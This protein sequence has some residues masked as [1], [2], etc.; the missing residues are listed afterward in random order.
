MKNRTRSAVA[1]IGV[2]TLVIVGFVLS[3]TDHKPATATGALTAGAAPNDV[4]YVDL[5]PEEAELKD[6]TLIATETGEDVD[7]VL[8]RNRTGGAFDSALVDLQQLS[9]YAESGPDGSGYYVAFKGSVP[10]EAVDA[11]KSLPV[12]VRLTADAP[13]TDDERSDA[14]AAAGAAIFEA[15]GAESTIGMKPQST[16][17]EGVVGPAN[18]T[19]RMAAS[20]PLEAL[21][22]DAAAAAVSGP[23]DFAITLTHTAKDVNSS[24]VLSGGTALGDPR[25]VKTLCTAGFTVRNDRT[26]QTGIITASHCPD[27]LDYEGRH[28]LNF[29]GHGDG[30]QLDEQWFTSSEPVWNQFI[31]SR[32]GATLYRSTV[33]SVAM[34]TGDREVCKFGSITSQGCSQ[35]HAG[36]VSAT[37]DSGV[38]YKNIWLTTR[39]ITERGDSGGPWF[40]GSTAYGVHTGQS[41]WLDGSTHSAFTP[42]PTIEFLTD[43]SVVR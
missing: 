19:R 15:T 7:A 16:E 22:E 27:D 39:H 38:T 41:V 9:A 42:V 3:P 26:G 43:L 37:Y 18:A 14:T 12:D 23:A 29:A 2:P 36:P 21:A 40:Y 6:A 34:P 33:R 32:S 20:V 1:L 25:G 13:L 31:S 11:V 24:E 17:M 30:Q 8:Q 10:Q 4:T 5:S 28:I 35:M